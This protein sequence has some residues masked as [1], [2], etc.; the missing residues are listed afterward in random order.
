MPKRNSNTPR[1][2]RGSTAAAGKTNDALLGRLNETVRLSAGADGQDAKARHPIA[3]HCREVRDGDG[4]TLKC[5]GANHLTP[6]TASVPNEAATPAAKFCENNGKL[7][8]YLISFDMSPL[9]SCPGSRHAV[10]RELRPDGKAKP[11]PVCWAC[12]KRYRERQKRERLEANLAFSR[13]DLFVPWAKEFIIGRKSTVKAV[14]LPGIGDLYSVA[15]VHK[16]HAIVRTNP[17]M[18]F[19]LYTRCWCVPKI[20]HELQKL[21][22]ERNL[23]IWLSW[24]RKMAEHHGPPP[25]RDLPWCWLAMADDDLPPEPVELVW[26]YDG[27]LQWNEKLPEKKVLGGCLVCP[28]ED[29]ITRTTCSECGICWRGKAFRNAKIAQLLNAGLRRAG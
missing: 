29:G 26:R 2:R 14:R 6:I 5:D 4:Q 20:W 25:D 13:T 18:Q 19:W 27:H 28:H 8:A 3:V 21:K 12:R 1:K 17:R 22:T 23:T 7:G 9:V 16:V 15:F 24:D 10:C 11:K